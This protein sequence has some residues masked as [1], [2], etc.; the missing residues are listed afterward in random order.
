M[1]CDKCGAQTLDTAK[2]CVRCG[3]PAGMAA[4]GQAPQESSGGWIIFG[5]VLLLLII[6]AVIKVQPFS[7]Y[8]T[9]DALPENTSQITQPEITAPVPEIIEQA[10]EPKELSQ[11]EKNA[12][13]QGALQ[14]ERD[15]LARLADAE[16]E[17]EI[18]HRISFA[19]KRDVLEVRISESYLSIPN[20]YGAD[21]TL[22]F[23]DIKELS[24]WDDGLI[25]I[26]LFCYS[27]S[28]LYSL[29]KAY[30]EEFDQYFLPAYDSWK[31]KH[32]EFFGKNKKYP[33]YIYPSGQT[34]IYPPTIIKCGL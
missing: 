24:T 27:Y 9:Q 13:T 5:V 18:I 17:T 4:T 11:E 32:S 33:Q 23:G 1:F 34:M 7:E 20:L 12:E 10:E 8:V 26:P 30:R 3:S 31:R 22:W 6:L 28:D 19:G 16:A 14:L 21:T 29:P 25:K 2:F 15:R